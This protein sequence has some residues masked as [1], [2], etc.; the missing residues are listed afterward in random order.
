MVF[1]WNILRKRPV[2]KVIAEKK[3]DYSVSIYL[4]CLVPQCNGN[5][6]F[7]H[8]LD[9]CNETKLKEIE[10]CICRMKFSS[11]QKKE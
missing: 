4:I 6:S 5:T 1:G 3:S 10:K 2:T 9:G 8:C 11:E 7:I